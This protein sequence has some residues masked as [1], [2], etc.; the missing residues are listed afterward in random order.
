[1]KVH[2]HQKRNEFI[3]EKRNKKLKDIKVYIIMFKLIRPNT[4]RLFNN[5]HIRTKCD[6]NCKES[7]I[8]NLLSKQIDYLDR[9]SNH[10]HT[11]LIITFSQLC[12][13]IIFVG[14]ASVYSL[15]SKII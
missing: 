4:I 2:V 1:M 6:L 5:I 9:I 11:M 14:A 10:T 3:I 13:P 15:I 8:N 12:A 7:C